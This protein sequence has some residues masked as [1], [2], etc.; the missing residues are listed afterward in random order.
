MNRALIRSTLWHLIPTL[1]LLVGSA[2]VLAG[3][4]SLP[5]QLI[6]VSVAFFAAGLLALG[7]VLLREHPLSRFGAA[8]AITLLR[9][10]VAA[11]L[12]GVAGCNVS[13]SGLAWLLV[14]VASVALVLD[15]VDGWLARRYGLVSPFG[16]RF[17]M[18]TDAVFI[19]AL[20]ILVW[21][22]GKAGPWVLLSGAMRYG[23]IAAGRCLPWLNR[24]LPPRRRRQAVC[25]IQ[26]AALVLCLAPPLRP[27]LSEVLAAAT[28]GLLVWSF[29]VDID[30]LWRRQRMH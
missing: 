7:P 12:F 21:Q 13:S 14:G 19:V 11:L 5:V 2:W 1:M 3:L 16:A 29:A 25:V 20:A 23:F 28:L 18:E 30:W 27:P 4:F 22:S 9:A 10:G 6:V 24:P 17:D 26:T 8:N 15:G